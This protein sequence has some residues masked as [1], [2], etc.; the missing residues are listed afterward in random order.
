MRKFYPYLQ[1]SFLSNA[2]T[3]QQQENFLAKINNFI[4]RKTY[5]KI[6]LLDWQENP[7]KAI[8]GEITS[9]NQS[10]D[11]ASAVRRT[12]SMSCVVD[13]GSYMIEDLSMDF[14]INKKVF[15][16]IG[17]RNDTDEYPEYPILWF[18]QG[19]FFINGIG[20]SS[21]AT[22]GVNINITLKDKMCMLNGDL[23]GKFGST[24]TF[25]VM[26]T[27]LPS[28]EYVEKK[29]L[30]YNII[31]ELVN[32]YGGE[33]LNNIVI[34]D[35]PLRIRRVMKW[36]ASNPLY[37]LNA[38][39]SE[40]DF[41]R[42][43]TVKEPS[44]EELKSATIFNK[45]D[46]VGYIYDDFFY[47]DELVAGPAETITSVLDKI[48]SYLGN[49]EYFYDVYGVFHFREIKNFTNTTQASFL[50]DQMSE[51]DY[52]VEVGTDKTVF[53]LSDSANITSI[54]VT[55][56]YNNI[57][58]D[59]IVQGLRQATDTQLSYPIMYHLAIDD[60]PYM[61]S[62]EWTL[63]QKFEIADSADD[64]T[65]EEE[66]QYRT[67]ILNL[68]YHYGSYNDIIIYKEPDTNIQ[69]AAAVYRIKDEDEEAKLPEV[70]NFNLI[71]C[72]E[73]SDSYYY[74][75]GEVYQTVT[76]LA[77]YT[78]TEYKCRDWRTKLYM[79]GVIATRR[80]IDP[81]YYYP[82][83]QAY[84]PQMYDLINQCFWGEEEANINNAYRSLTTG[85][86][87]LDFI[88]PAASS[89][90]EYSVKSIGRRTNVTVND[91]INCLFQPEIPNVVILDITDDNFDDLKRECIDAGQPWTGVRGD[92]FKALAT[93]GYH[94]GA[95]DQIKYDL[96]LYTRYQKS[97]SLTA[98]PAYWLEPNS[99]TRINEFT[100]NTYG[101]FMISNINYTFGPAATMSV[102]C[103][104]AAERF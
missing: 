6:T 97:V 13:G 48:K 19:V 3:E 66:P 79:D 34:E 54:T 8:E 80:G 47:T 71:Y 27:Q 44:A 104:E 2:T 85:I 78:K 95:F 25:D 26:D 91:D 82:E 4:N 15:V 33:D 45:D 42:T 92:V 31:Q 62:E 57:K 98:L 61:I 87:Y 70:G 94:N 18:P 67:E 5:T 59:F 89:L 63:I 40:S 41:S 24:V 103:S 53:T 90:G 73:D 38:D 51:K 35:V 12:C 58:N 99:R 29:V 49:Y 32:H 36:T 11:G 37:M 100:T 20:I 50:L 14:S 72:L 16:E 21:S 86:Y 84:W 52:L 83:L 1:D 43:Y 64:V 46:D 102:S 56:Q 88:D 81:G 22:G 55:P 96:Y 68:N 17:V 65:E 28:G 30:V 69:V 93:G 9:G 77:D 101:D 74:W 60:K 23:G 39:K 76:P 75:D 10:K 7:I